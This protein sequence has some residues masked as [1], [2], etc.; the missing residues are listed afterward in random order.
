MLQQI[1]FLLAN[2]TVIMGL[3]WN[4]VLEYEI[5]NSEDGLTG[6][7]AIKQWVFHSPG[8]YGINT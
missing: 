3:L 1:S 4:L 2:E 5:R 6:R 8:V 7:K